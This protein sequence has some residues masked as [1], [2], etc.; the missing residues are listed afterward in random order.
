VTLKDQ[1][2]ALLGATAFDST[3]TKIGAV[4]QVYVD[5]ATGKITFATVSTGIF[6]SDAIVPLHGARLLDGEL[7]VDHTRAAVR[8]SPRPDHT[9]DALTPDQELELLEHYGV[10]VPARAPEPA[11]KAA[12]APGTATTGS[13]TPAPKDDAGT[14]EKSGKADK[15][16]P[17]DKGATSDKGATPA[18]PAEQK[19][20][21]PK[22]QESKPG[23]APAPEKKAAKDAAKTPAAKDPAE[24]GSK[25]EGKGGAATPAGRP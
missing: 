17:A 8:D 13:P 6:S 2:D 18:T 22:R 4:R 10:E 25:D 23:P 14:T 24:P 5:D 20:Q 11:A 15:G 7:H 12:P 3:G 19:Q 9:E 21:E 1:L 16:T